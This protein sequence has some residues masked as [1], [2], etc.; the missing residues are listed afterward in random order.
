M[1]DEC[2]LTDNERESSAYLLWL[3]LVLS[4]R[5]WT[6]EDKDLGVASHA[7]P[8]SQASPRGEAKD[9]GLLPSRDADILVPPEPTPVFLPGE[10]HGQRSLAGYSP[11]GCTGSEDVI[12]AT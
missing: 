7:P 12:E 11:Q 3:I 2:L 10:S 5:L 4:Q 1:N 8:G 6:R 9:S